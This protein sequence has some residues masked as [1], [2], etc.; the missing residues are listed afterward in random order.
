MR[1]H[2]KRVGVSLFFLGLAG[3]VAASAQQ[4]SQP[5]Q[6]NGNYL[7]AVPSRL[8][9]FLNSYGDRL[10]KAGNERLTVTGT[11]HDA[12]GDSPALLI[13]ELPGKARLTISGATKKDL[14]FDGAQSAAAVGAIDLDDLD[15]LETF[16]NDSTEAFFFSYAGA[17]V[18][19]L[20]GRFR[21]GN[22][23]SADYKGPYYEVYELVGKAAVRGTT[24]LQQKLY[25]FDG[26]TG[27]LA[28]TRYKIQRKSAA[29]DVQTVYSNWKTTQGQSVPG[30][31]ERF[32]NGTSVLS[33]TAVSIALSGLAADAAFSHQ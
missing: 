31:I 29:I 10:Q 25:Y 11:Y 28:K 5:L 6:A 13:T 7:T 1:S 12:N 17:G 23:K 15:I 14:V 16:Q 30:K 18:R 22:D 24:P 27:L 33:F 19:F 20:G 2:R 4:V 26:A 9:P 21:A 8:L 32:E 3:C